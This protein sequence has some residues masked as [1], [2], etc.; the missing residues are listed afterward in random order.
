MKKLILLLLL[1]GSALAQTNIRANNVTAT[2]NV[3]AGGTLLVTGVATFTGVPVFSSG[4]GAIS[5]TQITNTGDTLLSTGKVLKWNA[6]TG[7][8]RDAA[9]VLDVG[10]GTQGDITGG[11]KAASI[12]V[13]GG[14]A[15]TSTNQTGTGKIVLDTAPAFTNS[16]QDIINQKAAT[17][18]LIKDNSGGTRLSIPA[19]GTS[20]A[21]LN[22]TNLTGGSTITNPQITGTPT[23]TGIPTLTLKQGTGLGNYT[24]ASTSYVVMDSTNLCYT[25]TIPTGWKLMVSGAISAGTLTAAVAFLIAIT[26]N[27][28][29]TTAN[30]G[31]LEEVGSAGLSPGAST[32][33]PI[34]WVIN[35][36]GAAHHVALQMKTTNAA[37]SV[38]ILNS[39]ATLNPV[40][41]FLLSPSN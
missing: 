6:D 9:G 18:F 29:C 3:S 31:I 5:S 41:T 1:C 20:Q 10:N 32:G 12:A 4:V 14:T 24:S 34:N 36:D 13:G 11:I 2:G 30:A 15:L 26:D 33:I 22:N 38:F 7:L 21:T 8:S 16:T 28:A 40:I 35:G 25:V 23:G 17:I 37:D 27:A 19:N 39:S